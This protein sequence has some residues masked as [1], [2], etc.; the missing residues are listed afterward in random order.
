VTEVV[1]LQVRANRRQGVPF[2]AL[3]SSRMRAA[4][5]LVRASLDAEQGEIGR[6]GAVGSRA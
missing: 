2:S 6:R 3:P 1:T 4:R 5:S